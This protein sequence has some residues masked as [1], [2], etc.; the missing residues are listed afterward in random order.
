MSDLPQDCL[1][2]L[3]AL[4]FS[5]AKASAHAFLTELRKID[6]HIQSVFTAAV[7]KAY[8]IHAPV[9]KLPPE[10]LGRIFLLCQPHYDDFLPRWPSP[11]S[12]LWTAITRVCTHWGHT[13]IS[14]PALWCTLDLSRN[15]PVEVGRTFLTRSAGSPLTVFFSSG[16]DVALSRNDVGVL[17]DAVVH[18]LARLKALHIV[19]ERYED[20]RQLCDFLKGTPQH[21]LSLSLRIRDSS[22]GRW[23]DEGCAV[24]D[25]HLPSVRKLTLSHCAAWRHNSFTNLSHFAAHECVDNASEDTEFWH[26][27]A[28]SPRLEVLALNDYCVN[29]DQPGPE[30]LIVPLPHLRS[31]Q[32]DG[33]GAPSTCA[34]LHYFDIP[35]TCDVHIS[36]EPAATDD[37][38]V[39]MLAP[40]T[41]SRLL[42][43]AFHTVQLGAK[44]SSAV[45]RG[46]IAVRSGTLFVTGIDNFGCLAGVAS[47]DARLV[48]M[49]DC[50]SEPP[51]AAEWGHLFESMPKIHTLVVISSPSYAEAQ[52][53][54]I[55]DA[56]CCLSDA[57]KPQIP[58]CPALENL[59]FYADWVCQIT[60]A[61][62]TVA[63][64]RTELGAP[65]R[66]LTIHHDP[67]RLATSCEQWDAGTVD[68]V[69]FDCFGLPEGFKSKRTLDFAD[70]MKRQIYVDAIP[71]HPVIEGKWAC[72]G[73]EREEWKR[74][75]SVI[76]YRSDDE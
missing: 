44:S 29:C 75:E 49:L 55:C 72:L 65:L 47:P 15:D 16:E 38:L 57:P 9:N 13:A 71:P 56:L 17:E 66:E 59:H 22:R 3:E 69:T 39:T 41:H 21:L 62:W 23:I 53:T 33:M 30:S 20:L 73:E 26:L 50:C 67:W 24:F 34:L 51:T 35:E 31:L 45:F 58:P 74:K 70:D 8:N 7:N 4:R 18:H 25:K 60:Y 12:L 54:D 1:D 43:R 28:S 64:F 37:E 46:R 11:R 32:F 52:M 27:L 63:G 5:I 14:L 10:L 42:Q 36:C 76:E 40:S 68:T 6:Q 2:A 48:I 19:V 61:A